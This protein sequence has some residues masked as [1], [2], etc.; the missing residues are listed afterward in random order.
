VGPKASR[1]AVEIREAGGS[2][3]DVWILS[4]EDGISE[5][6]TFDATGHDPTWTPDG[7]SVLVVS[8][9]V[10][11]SELYVT[12]ADGSG[13]RRVV[14]RDSLRLST[15]EWSGKA[16][17]IALSRVV[18]ETSADI[19]FIDPETGAIAPAVVGPG[20]QWKPTFS[21]NG[22]Y[23]AYENDQTVF[24]RSTALDGSEWNVSQGPGQ[25]PQWAPGGDAV[26]FV[27]SGTLLRV[28]VESEGSFRR[29]G[30]PEVVYESSGPVLPFA[31]YPDSD[32]LL[33]GVSD[34]ERAASS[35]ITVRL[36]SNIISEIE[37][38]APHENR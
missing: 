8:Y 22:K 27:R 20:A 7:D 25:D 30:N 17:I 35:Q 38:L 24:V 37:R 14:Y 9:V 29:R 33:I 5:Q 32:E 4:P 16:D 19:F 11:T 13:L 3:G 10:D 6:L 23:F 34:V 1:I 18:P 21:P 28:P 36:V 2:G 26:Y 31:S 12:A 15:P